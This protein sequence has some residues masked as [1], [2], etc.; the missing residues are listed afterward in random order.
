MPSVER[1][2]K[3]LDTVKYIVGVFLDPRKHFIQWIIAFSLKKRKICGI[4]T[5][6]LQ[7]LFIMQKTIF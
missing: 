2:T 4:H 3:A 6:L 7:K 1:V 5:Q